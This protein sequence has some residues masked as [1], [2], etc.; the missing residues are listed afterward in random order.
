MLKTPL[1]LPND[2]VL[3]ACHHRPTELAVMKIYAFHWGRRTPLDYNNVRKKAATCTCSVYYT[4]SIRLESTSFF[5]RE[6]ENDTISVFKCMGSC[7]LSKSVHTSK[8][9][10]SMSNLMV[11]GDITYAGQAN[12]KQESGEM[13]HTEAPHLPD[14]EDCLERG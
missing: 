7:I 4:W 5:T 6:S 3:E 2:T 1:F 10:P 13:K 11:L 8:Y 12:T 14:W 9:I